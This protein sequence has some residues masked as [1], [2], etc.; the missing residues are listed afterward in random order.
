MLLIHVKQAPLEV[1][2]WKFLEELFRK[3]KMKSRFCVFHILLPHHATTYYLTV[4]LTPT[5]IA[6][7]CYPMVFHQQ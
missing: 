4:L 2:F 6:T 1:F 3:T 7:N 5:F